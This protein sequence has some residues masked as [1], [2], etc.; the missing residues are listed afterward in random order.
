MTTEADENV[1]IATLTIGAV[2]LPSEKVAKE[3]MDMVEKAEETTKALRLAAEN[4]I[5]DYE[6]RSNSL[7]NAI[8]NHVI[9]CQAAQDAFKGHQ[10]KINGDE[11]KPADRVAMPN[12]RGWD[13][14]RRP[15]NPRND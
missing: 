8:N 6:D 2:R 9:A 14:P 15:P 4:L 7:A 10:L 12:T 5:K 3:L 1:R 11:D 13:D